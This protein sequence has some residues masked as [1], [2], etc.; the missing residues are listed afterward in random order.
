MQGVGIESQSFKLSIMNVQVLVILLILTG[1]CARTHRHLGPKGGEKVFLKG[2]DKKQTFS[3]ELKKDVILWDQLLQDGVQI[4]S[5]SVQNTAFVHIELNGYQLD[6]SD[7]VTETAFVINAEDW[8]VKCA[9]LPQS[10]VIDSADPVHFF[11]IREAHFVKRNT[12]VSLQMKRVPG[13]EVIP[14]GEIIMS[15]GGSA[16]K[17]ETKTMFAAV[18]ID[19]PSVLPVPRSA[20]Q[21]IG[22]DPDINIVTVFPGV[23]V[24]TLAE[25]DASIGKLSFERI[26]KLELSWEQSFY[27]NVSSRFTASTFY[28]ATNTEEIYRRILPDFSFS[29]RIFLLGRIELEAFKSLEL[30]HSVSIDTNVDAFITA[31]HEN[32]IRI[33]AAFSSRNLDIERLVPPDFGSSGDA[34]VDYDSV[35]QRETGIDGFFGYRAGVGVLLSGAGLKFQ[36]FTSAR[37]G[38]QATLRKKFPPFPPTSGANSA[39]DTCHGL[40]TGLS[41]IGRDLQTKIYQ[42]GEIRNEKVHDST[43]FDLSVPTVCALSTPCE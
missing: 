26:L 39:C 33:S 11:S 27:V 20:K 36:V 28:S 7:Y 3:V 40:E 16:D 24:S 30:M 23:T 38:L 37:L 4:K 9:E 14:S 32:L 15:P 34:D 29:R 6:K 35:L 25:L 8:N 21:S 19:G 43:L 10:S 5:C 22:S 41:I 17:N 42:D 12:V 2:H 1:A 31:T 13:A 18:K